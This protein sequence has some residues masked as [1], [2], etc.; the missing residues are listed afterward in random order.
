MTTLVSQA[1][2]H[3]PF[4][5]PLLSRPRNAAE[6]EA[7]AVSVDELLAIVGDD[8]DHPLMSLV[9]CLGDLIE[10]YDSSSRARPYASGEQVL[11]HLMA[12]HGL[13]QGD[14][15]ELGT[16][17]VVSELLAGKR[18]LNLRQVRFLVG[19]FAVPAHAFI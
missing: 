9:T 1:A 3:W 6:Y 16:Q 11:R 8:E 7:L 12:E 15:P 5:A 13:K 10:Q 17:S 18:K 4:V 19:R 14:L 2:A